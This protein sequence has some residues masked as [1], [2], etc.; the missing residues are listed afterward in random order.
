MALENEFAPDEYHPEERKALLPSGSGDD[1]SED[2]LE[3]KDGWSSRKITLTAL[4]LIVLLIM[5]A[6][7]LMVPLGRKGQPAAS[8]ILRSNGTH[9][10][11]PTVLIVSI[12]GLRC[13]LLPQEMASM[14]GN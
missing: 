5:G 2:I 7:T 11:K 8:S 10:F 4:A 1:N 13:V 9:E 6:F 14:Y 12:D 3:D